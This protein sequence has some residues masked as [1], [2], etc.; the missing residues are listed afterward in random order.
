MSKLQ[1]LIEQRAKVYAAMQDMRDKNE[2]EMP[3][4]WAAAESDF[5]RLSAEILT[6]QRWLENE[7]Q[8]IASGYDPAKTT[9]T[10][11]TQAPDT[12]MSYDEVFWRY[13]VRQQHGVLTPEEMRVLETRGTSTQIT[14]TNSLGGFLV[15]QSFSNLLENMMKFYGG[16]LD[17][18]G[19]FPDDIG[20]TLR[21]PTG[22]DTASTG[23]ISSTQASQRTVA[24]LAFGQVTFGDYTVDSNII[25][26]SR[27]LVQDERVGLL[28]GVL[29][30]NLSN[31]LGRKVNTVLTNG[32]GTNEPYGLTTV[33]TTSGLTTAG[34]TAITKNELIKLV[35]SVDKAYRYGP[36]VGFMMNDTILAY[37]RTLDVGNTD[38]VQ[39]FTPSLVAGEPDRLL[40]YPIFINN[41]LTAATS[42]APS[43]NSKH[44]YFGDFSKYKIRRVRGVS[45]ERNDYLYWD[46]LSV[47][48]MGWMRIDGNL[49][50]ANAIKFL[51]QHS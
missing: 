40:G 47:G 28:Q 35:H 3:E 8:M 25:K 30:E 22:D 1:N 43:A 26:V 49:I 23:N 7:R 24:D 34:A 51:T 17:A 19:V 39:I 2:G 27:E 46:S 33:V 31:R 15:P 38:T 18:C 42:F 11:A 5:Q 41:D 16:M 9:T 20:G 13:M 32:T 12:R 10:G 14:T 21:W 45:I 36:N 4:A 37:L 6:E 44:I 48:F 50:N 29:Q